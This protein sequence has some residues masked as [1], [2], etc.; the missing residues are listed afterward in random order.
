M[1]WNV[2]APVYQPHA[3]QFAYGLKGSCTL[4]AMSAADVISKGIAAY[5]LDSH[6]A[7]PDPASVANLQQI[8]Y[9]LY[10]ESRNTLNPATRRPCCGANGSA[11][12]SDMLVMARKI[13]LPVKEILPYAEPL[14]VDLW[15]DFI[16][17]NVAHSAIPYP[18]LMQVKNGRA[19]KDAQSGSA[20]EST[21]QYHAICIYGTQTDDSDPTAGGYL[22][23]D[24]DN[25]AINDHPV[26]YSLATLAAAQPISC[27][28]FDYVR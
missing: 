14:P 1:T 15:V 17:R 5:V 13:N 12:Q 16:R 20:D 24:G 8:M 28:A 27:I 26:V 6:A 10:L 9:R 23:C 7:H 21:L 18:V 22:V 4:L 25:P 3:S 11:A 19:L 2:H